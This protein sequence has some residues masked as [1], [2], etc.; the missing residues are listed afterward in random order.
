MKIPNICIACLLFYCCCSCS[1]DVLKQ[2]ESKTIIAHS[3]EKNDSIELD[4]IFLMSSELNTA[5]ENAFGVLN[6][7]CEMEDLKNSIVKIEMLGQKFPSVYTEDVGNFVQTLRAL[8]DCIS[9]T[10]QQELQ[11][12]E[13]SLNTSY[14]NIA[15]KLNNHINLD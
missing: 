2:D 8:L 7:T 15:Q 14:N 3:I 11:N 4:G 6:K 10:N 13:I 5:Y 12:M 1:G 9:S